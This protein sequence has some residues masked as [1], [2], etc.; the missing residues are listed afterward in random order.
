MSMRTSAGVA[1]VAPAGARQ[2]NVSN[3]KGNVFLIGVIPSSR[4]A[5]AGCLY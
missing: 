3:A 2:F 4:P 1:P 5:Q